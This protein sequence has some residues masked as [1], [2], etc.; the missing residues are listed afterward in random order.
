MKI[1]FLARHFGYL[2]N[3]ES[4][5]A[6]LASRGHTLH[7]A[8]DRDEAIGGRDLVQRLAKQHPDQITVGWTPDREGDDWLWLATKFRLAQDFL[9]YLDPIYDNATHL[10]RRAEERTPTAVLGLIRVLGIGTGV[11]RRVMAG[12]LDILERAVPRHP[13]LDTFIRD[14]APDVVL[15]TPLV[16]LGSPQLDHLKS[17]RAQ[18]LRTVL[19]VGSWDHLSSK[20][21]IRIPPDRVTVWNDTQRA[22]AVDLHHL[23]AERVVVTGAQC[24]DHWFGRQPSRSREEFC[25]ELGLPV[26]R[27]FILWLASSLFRG[28][29]PEAELVE[30]WIRRLRGSADPQLRSLAVVV[31]PH[32]ARLDEWRHVDLSLFDDVVR[33]GGNPIEEGAKND[34]FDSMSHA[35][36]VVGLNTSAMLEAGIVGRPVLSI[37]LDDYKRN[38]EGTLHWRYL[39]EVGG[40]LLHVAHGF[41][42]HFVQLKAAINDPHA[43]ADRSRKF[44]EAF[45][46]PF[47]L[48]VAATPRFVQAIEALAAVPAPRP[49]R[50]GVATF[51]GRPLLLPLIGLRKLR[52]GTIRRGKQWRRARKRLTEQS[53]RTLRTGLKQ[54]VLKRVRTEEPK[55]ILPK[56]ERLRLRAQSMFDK[57]EEVE[58]TKEALMRLSRSSRPILVGPWL[59]ETGF[60]LLYWIP[61]LHWAKTFGNLR[62][63]RLVVVSRGNTTSWY[64][65]LTTNYVDVFDFF[66]QDE[67]RERNDQRIEQQG[68]QLKHVDVTDF[69]KDIL[70]RVQQSRGGPDLEMIHPSLMYNLFRIFW[71][72]QASVGLV[73]GYTLH[74]K[75]EAPPL[76][77]LAASLPKEYIAVRF[78][79]NRGFPDTPRNRAFVSSYLSQL[80]ESSEIVVLNTGLRLDD[81]TDFTSATR[82][83]IHTVEHLMDARNNLDTQT[84]IIGG[85]KAFIGTYG[86]FAYLAPLM[87]VPTLSFYSDPTGFRIDHLEIA[88]R[89]YTDLNSASFLALDVRDVDVLRIALGVGEGLLHAPPK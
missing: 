84:R 37:V 58:D 59:T 20:S 34:Y 89:A 5:I 77:T 21:L 42:E 38:Q 68:G 46:R 45:I 29:K 6:A 79:T 40:G 2:R 67:F 85:A 63:D 27:A 56:P 75:L 66:T 50:A 15:I 33:R 3:Y 19:C 39:Q 51:F 16:D 12:T 82:G 87:G 35:A 72:L 7:L 14:Q 55:L 57:V 49:H 54:L 25:R 78:Y 88:K 8:A 81:H 52:A 18:G 1:L 62:D 9:R 32:P 17:A 86:G 26:D 23:S 4:V 36:A 70:E 76:G 31:R 43:A 65:H 24:F 53:R 64:Q 61:F 69:D 74:R 30:E 44:V 48:D 83:R 80:A 41:D 60:E 47:G 71:R 13:A 73:Q 28:S 22:E 10:R 11:G